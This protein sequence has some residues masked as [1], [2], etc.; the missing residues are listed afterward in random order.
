MNADEPIYALRKDLLFDKIEE[1]G[2]TFM[3][4]SDPR[5]YANQAISFPEQMVSVFLLLDGKVTLNDL[6]KMLITETGEDYDTTPLINLFEFLDYGGYMESPRFFEIKEDIDT[7]LKSPLRPAICAPD[8]YSEDP[9]QLKE[10]LSAIMNSVDASTIEKKSNV[11]IS[12]HLD[13]RTGSDTH[14][15]YASA[16]HSADTENVDI[17]V[18]LGTSHFVDTGL[19]MLSEKD[20]ETPLG[21]VETDRELIKKMSDIFAGKLVFDEVAHR[22]EHSIELQ[23]LPIQYIM[24]D[25]DYKILPILTGSF[26]KFVTSGTSPEDDPDFSNFIKALNDALKALGR[27]AIFVA[28]ADFAHIGRKFD[29]SFDAEPELDKLRAEDQSLIDSLEAADPD[30]FFK[31]IADC[32]DARKIC[33]LSPIYSLLKISKPKSGKLLKYTQW[34]EVET[35]SAVS[36]AS[37]SFTSE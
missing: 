3:V 36:V 12:P 7:Y 20:F 33:G 13:Y 29:D 34:N 32:G 19:F 25:R 30:E 22:Y 35:K 9:E 23:L 4:M 5:G 26:H 21:V 14:E 6:G 1:N 16:Y 8:S 2:Q 11:I 24:K 31:K 15:A 10:E 37:M 27:K 17:I 28:A 18:I